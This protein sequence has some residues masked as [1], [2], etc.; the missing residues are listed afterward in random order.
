MTE[1]AVVSPRFKLV[2]LCVLGLTVLCFLAYLGLAIFGND[3]AE[4][5]NSF[6]SMCDFGFKAGFGAILGLL[7][8]KVS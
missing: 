7:G 5:Q 4:A 8:G 2:L 6:R 1:E 3:D